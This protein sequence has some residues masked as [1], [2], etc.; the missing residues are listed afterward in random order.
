MKTLGIIFML[1]V[2]LG[3]MGLIV[4]LLLT[5]GIDMLTTNF[6]E[7]IENEQDPFDRDWET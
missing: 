7:R 5:F 4:Y 1:L 3:V 2:A 6:D